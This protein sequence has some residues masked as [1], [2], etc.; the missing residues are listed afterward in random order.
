VSPIEREGMRV[1]KKL[2]PEQ[3]GAI[4]LARRYGD[5]LACVRYRRSANGSHRYT[6]IELIADCV[7]VETRNGKAERIVGVRPEL[8]TY[9]CHMDATCSHFWPAVAACSRSSPTLTV[10]P[11]SRSRSRTGK[12]GSFGA[13][14][15]SQWRQ[16]CQTFKVGAFAEQSATDR[17]LRR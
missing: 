8:T 9:G 12:G 14:N 16:L 1:L 5:A 10:S 15:L 2:G 3:A 17:L 13:T 7:A 11:A 4:K 6:A